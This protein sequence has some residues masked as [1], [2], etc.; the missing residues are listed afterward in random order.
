MLLLHCYVETAAESSAYVL[1]NQPAQCTPMLH[2]LNTIQLR[3]LC[4]L[5]L[6]LCVG[7]HAGAA[8]TS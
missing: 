1:T 4:V 3:F 7:K 6:C 8:Y 5:Q 2:L